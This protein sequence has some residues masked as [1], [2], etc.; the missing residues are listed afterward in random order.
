MPGVRLGRGC[1]WLPDSI[2][3][4][5]VGI[6]DQLEGGIGSGQ[7][8]HAG[9]Q[10]LLR[11]CVVGWVKFAWHHV[12]GYRRL[13]AQGQGSLQGPAPSIHSPW[14]S[15]PPLP[16]PAFQCPTTASE[17]PISSLASP[18]LTHTQLQE[19]L[20]QHF[21]RLHAGCLGFLG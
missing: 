19:D 15:P 4:G 17:A 14:G 8:E 11:E 3:G 7:W 2:D 5:L 1:R 16:Q 18:W 12:H 20:I 9:V 10:G 6:G 21:D 13:G